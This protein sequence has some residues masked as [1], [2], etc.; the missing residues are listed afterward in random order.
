M[1]SAGHL[2][3]STYCDHV[4]S[5]LILPV[6]EAAVILPSPE[7]KNFIYLM[8]TV[9]FSEY[10]KII[11]SNKKL[12][13]YVA[14][15]AMAFTLSLG[16][17]PHSYFAGRQLLTDFR[18]ILR[19]LTSSD[20]HLHKDTLQL[21]SQAPLLTE[22]ENGLL[23]LCGVPGDDESVDEQE[24]MRDLNISLPS[25]NFPVLV[26]LAWNTLEDWVACQH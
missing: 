11:T 1:C 4:V 18:T 20:L 6:V 5:D 10:R 2:D 9:F 13:K 12:Y 26:E 8:T 25:R 3:H 19:W 24:L 21:L 23:A 15:I 14:N 7:Q 16:F 22:I 17:M